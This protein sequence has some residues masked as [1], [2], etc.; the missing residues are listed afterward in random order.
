MISTGVVLE[1]PQKADGGVSKPQLSSSYKEK[2]LMEW[3]SIGGEHLYLRL[4][5]V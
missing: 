5:T 2:K 3:P 4:K 1:V